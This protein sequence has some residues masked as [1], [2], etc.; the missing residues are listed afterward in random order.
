MKRIICI[1]VA[2]FLIASCAFADGTTEKKN[3]FEF[4]DMYMYHLLKMK[5]ELGLDATHDLAHYIGYDG[6]THLNIF[7]GDGQY[8]VEV[9][10]GTLLVS[11]PDFSVIQLRM[12][13][14]SYG[15]SNTNN[16]TNMVRAAA[17]FA[18]LEYDR[19]NDW[20]YPF[21]HQ[22]DPSKPENVMLEAMD[23]F[24]DAIDDTFD[25]ADLMEDFFSESGNIIPFIS[26]NYEYSLQYING[27]EDNPDLEIVYMVVDYK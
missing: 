21:L 19:L 13:F 9:P 15:S 3:A 25:N 5:Y 1:A 8:Y 7:A 2:L 26:G 6:L 12:W 4:C 10:A 24:F 11:V 16:E 18:A 17:A 23:R 22:I 14:T 27:G 20:S